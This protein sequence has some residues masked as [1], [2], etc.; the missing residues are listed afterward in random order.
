MLV[1]QH[2][3]MA[4][5]LIA[6]PGELS[7]AQSRA[8]E[9]LVRDAFGTSFRTHDWLHGVDGVHVLVTDNGALIAHA[10]VVPRTLWHNDHEFSTGYVESVAVR[11]D[12]QGRGLGRVIMDHAES[13]IVERHDIGALN[14]VD[15]AAAFYAARGWQ[16][17]TGPHRSTKLYRPDRHIQ[18][19]RPHLRVPPP[20][21]DQQLAGNK[22]ADMRLAPRRSLVD[23][24]RRSPTKPIASRG[25]INYIV[26]NQLHRNGFA[27]QLLRG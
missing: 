6:E 20:V 18:R 1:W 10:S 2:A 16:Q 23:G 15:T 21:L 7:P 8:A 3:G 14:A 5:V 24:H 26:S 25:N 27:L 22:S 4:D 19:R 17:W 11:A 12:Q 13:I 9:T